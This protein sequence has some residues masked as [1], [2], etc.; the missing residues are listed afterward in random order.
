M[1]Q[2]TLR[3]VRKSYGSVEVIKGID[4]EVRNVVL[5][6]QPE[7]PTKTRNSPSCTSRSMP[8]MTSTLP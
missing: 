5:L 7:G 2:V 6:P 8:L 4:L 3:G 1:G